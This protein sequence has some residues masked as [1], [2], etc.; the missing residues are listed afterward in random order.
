MQGNDIAWFSPLAQ[1]VVFDG[2]LAS[3]PTNRVQS[4]IA[5]S[6]KSRGDWEKYINKWEPHE[7]PL[8]ALSDGVNRLGL[9]TDIYT[10]LS[11]DAVDP[12]ERWL[13]RKGVSCAVYFYEDARFL[14]YDLRFNRAVRIIYTSSEEVAQI[15]GPRATVVPNDRAWTP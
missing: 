9:G 1:G 12:I 5:R 13:F 7:M 11:Q 15:L 6:L 10:F 4:V 14:E 8:K 3:P 2:L